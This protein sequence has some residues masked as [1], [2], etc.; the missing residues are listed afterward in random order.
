MIDQDAM[1]RIRAMAVAA[2]CTIIKHR[3]DSAQE[4]V[5]AGLL[6]ATSLTNAVQLVGA[7]QEECERFHLL[8]KILDDAASLIIAGSPM[9]W[10]DEKETQWPPPKEPKESPHTTN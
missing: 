9:E 8:Q 10:I 1:V 4:C 2:A 7:N 3:A 6:I 5:A